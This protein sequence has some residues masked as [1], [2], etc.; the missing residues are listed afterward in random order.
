MCPQSCGPLCQLSL[1]S[2]PKS[3]RRPFVLDVLKG[4]AMSF[5]FGD[6]GILV[7]VQWVGLI[8]SRFR[9]TFVM[10]FDAFWAWGA[11]KQDIKQSSLK[12]GASPSRQSLACKG[13]KCRNAGRC[14]VAAHQGSKPRSPVRCLL[15]PVC[16]VRTSGESLT[17][18]LS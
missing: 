16:V 3:I 9:R 6:V 5:L 15:Q 12:M 18:S 14:R 17:P 4:Y 7:F 8:G 11:F 13:G 2:L 1:S 10:H